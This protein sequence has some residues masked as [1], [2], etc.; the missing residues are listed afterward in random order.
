METQTELSGKRIA[1][2][3]A[4]MSSELA[5]L[6]KRHGGEPYHAPALREAALDAGAE[7]N[8]FIDSLTQ[9]KIGFVIFQTG[10]GV[11]GL[12]AE[13]DKLQRKDE[14]LAL[15][16]EVTTIARGPKPTAVL[17]RN[18]LKP[19]YTT[20]EPYTTTELIAVM[21][22][23]EITDKGV[24][25]LHYGERNQVLTEALKVRGAKLHELCLYEWQL[26]ADVTPLKNLIGEVVA[27]KMD[28]VAFTSQIQARHLFQIANELG[29]AEELRAALN[30]KTVVA[31]IGPTCTATLQ[32][33]GITPRVEPEH[34]KMGPMVLALKSYFAAQ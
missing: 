34:P 15:L 29:Q 31:S 10:V 1:L 26:P 30:H 32:S 33:F 27:G 8:V 23:L 28:A 17:A 21:S 9:E 13:A 12:L 6:V 19:T 5:N 18:G 4:R 11:A 7:V 2:L 22:E 14:L 25:V 3:E 24:A 16:R 20:P